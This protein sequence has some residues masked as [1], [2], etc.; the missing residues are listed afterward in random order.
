MKSRILMLVS[1]VILG[2][3]L[4]GAIMSRLNPPQ[5][6]PEIVEHEMPEEPVV[7]V[8]MAKEAM[9]AGQVVA[10]S[11][12]RLVKTPESQALE[13]GIKEDVDLEFVNQMVLNVDVEAGGVVLPENITRPNQE[14]YF[15]L[16][17]DPEYVPYP[18]PIS[19]SL[20]RGGVL[21]PG[22]IVDVIAL[23]SPSQ[24]LSQ[25]VLVRNLVDVSVKPVLMGVKVLQIQMPESESESGSALLNAQPP[26][27]N[28]EATVVLQL[29]QKQIS[30][31]SIARRIAHIELYVSKNG[32]LASDLSSDSGDVMSEFRIV[33]E[34]RAGAAPGAVTE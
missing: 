14:G 30:T 2:I 12:L 8:W 10:R 33:R 17:I 32:T 15:N 20:V 31:I 27:V 22:S 26:V 5:S 29:T 21:A 16:V 19:K 3:G 13:F 18:L 4:V 9:N 6:T 23:G 24:N 25:D 11:D 7:M 28:E 1:L 34:L